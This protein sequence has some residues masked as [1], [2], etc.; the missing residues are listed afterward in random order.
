M[1]KNKFGTYVIENCLE[2]INKI[3]DEF[4]ENLKLKD[5]ENNNSRSDNDEKMSFEDFIQFKNKIFSNIQNNTL[6]KDK[7]K[8]LKLIRD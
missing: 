5:D 1:I 6:I 2:L 4:F 3:N 8:I 7:K